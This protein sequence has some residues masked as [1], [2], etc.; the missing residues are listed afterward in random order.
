LRILDDLNSTKPRKKL[1]SNFA[2]I[3][4]DNI[5]VHDVKYLPSFFDSY[6]LFVLPFVAFGVSSTYGYSMDDIDKM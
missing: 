2:T 3:D 4:F 5:E 6:V 1:K